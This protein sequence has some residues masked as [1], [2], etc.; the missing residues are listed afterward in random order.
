M[1]RGP[2]IEV[3]NIIKEFNG[4]KAL[5]GASL[6]A[7][8]G[9][10]TVIAGPSGAGKTT[11]LRIIA[12]FEDPDKGD[13]LFN[14]AS[15]LRVPPWKRGVVLLSQR[16]VLLPH[17]T[18][19]DNLILAAEARGVSRKEAVG[20]ARRIAGRFGL[21]EFL[22]RLPGTLSGGQLQRASL[23]SILASGPRV[24]LLDEPF[25]HLDLPLRESFRRLIREITVEEEITTI[26]VT[27]D[28]DE[29]LEVADKLAVIVNGRIVGLGDPH[30]FYYKPS[31][32]EAAL[33]LGHNLSCKPPFS[34]RIGVP[35]TFPPEAV[36]LGEGPLSGV[37]TYTASRK[38]YTLVYIRLDGEEIRGVLFGVRRVPLGPIRFDID[39]S[40][41]S[42]WEGVNCPNRATLLGSLLS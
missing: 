39:W 6:T 20:I 42:V 21:E 23:A 8:P 40:L 16:P 22:D 2:L 9:R 11:L 3:R 29:A 1:P 15:I 31:S 25:A 30:D 17:L 24:L 4:V 37:T 38:H 41:V 19:M 35:S 36:I 32:L 18:V 5:N 14:G 7:E 34:P 12:G 28:Q 26:E 10:I 27:H 33:F 13:V